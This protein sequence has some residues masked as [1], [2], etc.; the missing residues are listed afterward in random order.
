MRRRK[1]GTKG[2][3]VASAPCGTSK[4]EGEEAAELAGNRRDVQGEGRGVQKLP[5]RTKEG[6][7]AKERER[8]TPRARRLSVLSLTVTAASPE[9]HPCLIRSSPFFS[10]LP[11]PRQR[12]GG[13]TES[14]RKRERRRG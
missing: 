5:R 13:R 14:A 9:F 7:R 12:E 2:E 4:V 6:E 8:E 10:L 11:L 3:T 1:R